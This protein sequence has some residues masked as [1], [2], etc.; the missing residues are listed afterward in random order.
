MPTLRDYQRWAR[1]GTTA[2]RGY[3]HDHAKLRAALL[4]RWRPGDPCARCGQPMWHRWLQV[5]GKQV[6]AIDLGHTA[7]RT[8]YT[9][10]EHRACNRGDGARRG[11]RRR[12]Q[13][14]AVSK[15]QAGSTA[16][17]VTAP[18]LRTSRQW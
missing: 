8:A 10:L 16:V 17:T 13:R 4:A 5:N 1:K 6:S 15:Q 3:G 14:R 12:G 18:P 2:Q 9:G 11:N 7:D